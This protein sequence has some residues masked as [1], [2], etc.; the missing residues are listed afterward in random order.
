[1]LFASQSSQE[2]Y[3]HQIFRP[4]CHCWSSVVYV[5]YVL[6][7]HHACIIISPPPSSPRSS[8]MG[9]TVH[10]VYA[11]HK[12]C[13][14]DSTCKFS[15]RLL[16]T[17]WPV[18]FQPDGE[19][20]STGHRA[21]ASC[22]THRIRM[23]QDKGRDIIHRWIMSGGT[24][25]SILSSM[26][27]I[28]YV[29][30]CKRKGRDCRLKAFLLISVIWNAQLTDRAIHKPVNRYTLNRYLCNNLRGIIKE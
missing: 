24:L 12:L 8:Y 16:R 15:A 18:Q 28:K 23:G 25:S 13:Y 10:I 29:T 3:Q 30:D 26:K 7:A 14:T 17:P 27:L 11:H 19:R 9:I 21:C 22:N 1:M 20:W 2:F 5:E 4:H 6:Y